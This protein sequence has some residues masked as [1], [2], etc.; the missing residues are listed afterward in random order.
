MGLKNWFFLLLFLTACGITGN[1]VDEIVIDDHEMGESP[2]Q[3]SGLL[4]V[5]PDSVKE[6]RI[7]FAAKLRKTAKN[8]RPLYEEYIGVIGANGVLDGIEK[9]WPK[10]HSEAHDLG[11]V[12]YAKLNDIGQGLGVCADRCYS[13]CMH[14][15]LMEAFAAYHD[16][17]DAEGHVDLEKL[18]PAMNDLCFNDKEMI[19]SYSPGDCAHGLGH[20]LM[21]LS[22]YDVPEAIAGCDVFEEPHMVYYCATGTYMEYVTEN[23]KEDAKVKS[24]FYPCDEFDYPAACFRYKMVHV[25]NRHYKNKGTTAEIVAECEKFEGKFRLGC[26]HG[27]GNGHMPVIATG[28]LSIGDVCLTGSEDEKFVCIE[29]AI[30]R[31]AKYHKNLALRACKSLEGKYNDICMAAVGYGM[32]NMEKDLSLYMAE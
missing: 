21:F 14:G 29:G 25:S 6:N 17:D 3:T 28:K 8:K 12:I 32:Y 27:L 9:L 2:S 23:D 11:K 1:V 13:G 16:T 31:M 19:S 15:V 18:K 30:E 20:A 7:E 5:E 26:F 4:F 22:G 10:C 24:L